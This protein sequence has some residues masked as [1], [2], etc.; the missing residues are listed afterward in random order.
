MPTALIRVAVQRRLGLPLFAAAAAAAGR[1]KSG[2]SA[3]D[4][5]SASGQDAIVVLG[6]S[7]NA[8]GSVPPVLAAR[9][10]TAAAL[11]E[12]LPAALLVTTGGDPAGAGT[13]EAA[14]SR[15]ETHK[16]PHRPACPGC[17]RL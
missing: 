9:V 12:W 16:Y 5:M 11:A 4:C 3:Y 7:L 13:T 14:R 8:D 2:G 17:Q 1:C 6:Q 15:L 10:N